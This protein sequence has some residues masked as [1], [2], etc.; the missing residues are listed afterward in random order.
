MKKVHNERRM[1]PSKDEPDKFLQRISAGNLEGSATAEEAAE[2]LMRAIANACDAS[3]PRRLS[4]YHRKPAYWWN[5]ELAG[6]RNE[7]NKRRR[8]FQRAR[9]A[10]RPNAIEE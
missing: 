4:T 10:N 8:D 5:E 1:V 7:C 6:L 3:M 2:A 9:K